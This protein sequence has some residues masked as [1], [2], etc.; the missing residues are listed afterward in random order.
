MTCTKCLEKSLQD[1]PGGP[2]VKN[3]PSNTGDAGSIPSQGTKITQAT[4]QL[5]P[6]ASTKTR[7]S[8][9]LKAH[10]RRVQAEQLEPGG[11]PG[12]QAQ[13]LNLHPAPAHLQLVNL[14]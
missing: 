13:A 7:C 2:V 11:L 3:P 10:H 5:N 6:P 4:G 12:L 14:V 9:I 8:Q 1:F